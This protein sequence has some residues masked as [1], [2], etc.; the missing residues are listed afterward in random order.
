MLQINSMQMSL[1][2]NSA[3]HNMFRGCWKIELSNC[4]LTFHY[5]DHTFP[6]KSHFVVTIVMD[7]F[8][9]FHCVGFW[10]GKQGGGDSAALATHGKKWIC[11]TCQLSSQPSFWMSIFL[12]ILQ[13]KSVIVKKVLILYES[14]VVHLIRPWLLLA[15][16]SFG[17]NIA[18][19][20]FA[21]FYCL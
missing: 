8:M 14:C 13:A 10:T 21:T 1:M 18:W 15:I 12:K 11:V 3:T 20:F 5:G 6:V 19:L 2:R 4:G 17:K 16:A 7:S 9:H